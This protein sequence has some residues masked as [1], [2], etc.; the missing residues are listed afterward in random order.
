MDQKITWSL[1]IAGV[2]VIAGVAIW[3]IWFLLKGRRDPET[4][5]KLRK[6]LNEAIETAS[7]DAVT[8]FIDEISDR[9]I[10]NKTNLDAVKNEVTITLV[11]NDITSRKTELVK[12]Y[13]KA[14]DT[15][16][17]NG[18]D[19]SGNTGLTTAQKKVNAAIEEKAKEIVEDLISEKIK[20]KASCLS[21]KSAKSAT[22]DD[23]WKLVEG[24][25]DKKNAKANI[26][27][28]ARNAANA[29]LK[30]IVT[31]PK[32]TVV[33]TAVKTEG[34]T[35]L[36]DKLSEITKKKD[37]FIDDAILEVAKVTKK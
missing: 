3:G 12:K 25:S 30:E 21:E 24:L 8:K 14:D 28:K 13:T 4:K 15:S 18:V 26:I 33:E 22:D 10:K 16:A 19:S 36:K 37:D 5:N 27:E 7:A 17:I 31:D 6:E 29:K 35:A 23:V 32:W 20:E 2:V 9:F 1:I 11:A 34:N